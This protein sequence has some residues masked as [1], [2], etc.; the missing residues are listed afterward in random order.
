MLRVVTLDYWDTIYVGATVPERSQRRREALA[1]LL[2]QIGADVPPLEFERVYV[3]SAVEA[4]RWW[5]DEH[6]GYSTADRI[7][8]LLAQ[9]A[10]ERPQ[11]CEHVA[12]AVRRIDETLLEYPPTLLPGAQDAI[13]ALSDRFRL[14]IV[15]DTGFASGEAQNRVLARD[16]LLSSFSTTIYSMDI[17]HAKP[18]PEPFR[19]ALIALGATP[20]EALHVGDNERSDVGGAL[21][22]GMRAIRLDAVRPN[23]ESRGELVARSLGEVAE[24]LLERGNGGIGNGE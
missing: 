23:G 15:S 17:G 2:L 18:R 21:A 9:L 12:V 4:A 8:W 24:Y 11:D 14:G 19:A 20:A 22:M 16:G 10:I 1:Q 5:R 6:R 7:R 13:R 3:A